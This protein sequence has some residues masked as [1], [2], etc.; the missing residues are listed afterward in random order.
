MKG[1][2]RLQTNTKWQKKELEKYFAHKSLEALNMIPDATV[3]VNVE[4]DKTVVERTWSKV[5]DPQKAVTVASTSTTENQATNNRA[6]SREP[7]LVSQQGPNAATVVN[8]R[9]K[10]KWV[11]HIEKRWRLPPKRCRTNTWSRS[12]QG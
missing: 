7:G 8:D 10:G 4:L 11:D 5:H 12:R 1:R 6:I 9:R 3:V 2:P